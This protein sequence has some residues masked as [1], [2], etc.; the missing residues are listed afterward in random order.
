MG[1]VNSWMQVAV[2]SFESRA[3]PR[4][5]QNEWG[6]QMG[7]SAIGIHLKLSDLLPE[8]RGKGPACGQ[9]GF[10]FQLAEGIISFRR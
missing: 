4:T 1:M 5:N 3:C 2:D 10:W 8:I 7:R 9:R 6:C